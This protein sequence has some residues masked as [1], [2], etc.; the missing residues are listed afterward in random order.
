[1]KIETMST[2]LAALFVAV[3]IAATAGLAYTA[4]QQ[5]MRNQAVESCFR[6][7]MVESVREGEGETKELKITEP[8]REIYTYCLQDKGYTSVIQGK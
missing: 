8:V 4:A 7:G 5:Q 2:P 6:A 3:A 1:M